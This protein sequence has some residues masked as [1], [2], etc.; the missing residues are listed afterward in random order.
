MKLLHCIY[1]EITGKLGYV[2][3]FGW[4]VGD[5]CGMLKAFPKVG[6]GRQNHVLYHYPIALLI[7][8]DIISGDTLCMTFDIYTYFKSNNCK[9][10]FNCDWYFI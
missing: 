10:Y 5:W 9:Y 3:K 6:C 1:F 7:G 4:S 2:L 8:I